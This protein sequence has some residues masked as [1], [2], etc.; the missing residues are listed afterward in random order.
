MMRENLGILSNSATFSAG[1][2]LLPPHNF[3][4]TMPSTSS[5]YL[6]GFVASITF[7]ETENVPRITVKLRIVDYFKQSISG[8]P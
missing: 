1:P 7:L 8:V 6:L 5:I 3:S 4:A 2:P